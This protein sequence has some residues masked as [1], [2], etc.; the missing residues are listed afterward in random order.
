MQNKWLADNND[1]KLRVT[2][3]HAFVLDF[4]DSPVPPRT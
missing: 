1:K 4:G 3:L 2:Q